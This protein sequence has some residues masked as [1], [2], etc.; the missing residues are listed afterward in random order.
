MC[1]SGLFLLPP[2]RGKVG[3]GGEAR[4][5]R[6]RGPHP[7][8]RL[9]R[10]GGG[11][12]LEPSWQNLC[13]TVLAL[14]CWEREQS[15]NHLVKRLSRGHERQALLIRC[16]QFNEMRVPMRQGTPQHWGQVSW[17]GDTVHTAGVET[18]ATGQQRPILVAFDHAGFSALIEAM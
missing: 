14:S 12:T 5:G 11:N 10:R 4:H 15:E 8:P 3:M 18:I 13:R 7:H 2:W 16:H 6:S 17:L 1:R 9:P